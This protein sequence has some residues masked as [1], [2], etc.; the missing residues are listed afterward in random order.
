ME[1]LA[2]QT[3]RTKLMV[4]GEA[5]RFAACLTANR[6]FDRVSLQESDRAKHPDRRWF[7]EYA[8]SN[9][10][11]VADLTQRQQEAR[12]AR[13]RAEGDAYE[14][15]ADKDGGRACYWCLSVSGGVYGL[16]P[17]ARTCTCPDF[18]YRCQPAGLVCKHL[19]ALESGLGQ[20]VA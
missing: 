4:A 15:I 9:P 2:H 10:E 19:I 13:A 1:I 17:T 6:R 14:F 3:Y 8:A 5:Q 18:Q 20:R 12:V 16:D 7:V 11:R